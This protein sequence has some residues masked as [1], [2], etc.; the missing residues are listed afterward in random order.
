MKKFGSFPIILLTIFIVTFA[1]GC[2]P[3]GDEEPAVPEGSDEGSVDE[4]AEPAP[5]SST[6]TGEP[7]PEEDAIPDPATPEP[8]Q[9]GGQSEERAVVGEDETAIEH[10]AVTP[11][12]VDL[13]QIT[14]PPTGVKPTPRIIP[15]PG[16]PNPS[17]AASNRA[18]VNLA[19]ELRL[20]V[21]SVEVV[22]VEAVEW[23]DSSLGCPKPGQNYMSVITPG[24]RVVLQAGGQQYEYHTNQDGTILVQCQSAGGSSSGTVDR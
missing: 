10:E 16:I 8:D 4:P 11:A 19:D 14:P 3:A 20:D 23:R 17:A 13:R 9:A 2:A 21:E 18:A 22:S 15:G 24:F 5:V 1:I 12:V 6:A 7:S